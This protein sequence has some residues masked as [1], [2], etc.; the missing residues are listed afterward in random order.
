M[1]IVRKIANAL[2]RRNKRAKRKND[3]SIYPMF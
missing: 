1:S 3:A 2:F